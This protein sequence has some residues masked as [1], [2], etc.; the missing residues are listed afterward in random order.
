[1]LP[2]I[3][4]EVSKLALALTADQP[5]INRKWKIDLILQSA[6]NEGGLLYS[7]PA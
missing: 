4:L 1:M 6:M 5:L 3:A 7:Q 2:T